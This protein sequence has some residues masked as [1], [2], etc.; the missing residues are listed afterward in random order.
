LNNALED[1]RLY[2]EAIKGV[3]YEDKS[4]KASIDA[5]DESAYRRGKADIN[6]SNDQMYSYHHWDSVMGGPLMK[7]GYM[8]SH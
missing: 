6:L 2:V 8:K 4:L 5:Y 3:Y 7:N 1:A